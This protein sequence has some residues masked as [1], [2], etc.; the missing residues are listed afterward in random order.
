MSQNNVYSEEIRSLESAAGF[1]TD[2]FGEGYDD[3]S[4][5]LVNLA[6]QETLYGTL[7]SQ[8]YDDGTPVSLTEY[9]ID[10]IRY[11]DML[12]RSE[13]G[14]ALDRVNK[15]NEEFTNLGY[16]NFDIRNLASTE[17]MDITDPITGDVT[18]QTRY[19]DINK[20]LIEDPYVTA[21]LA[22]HII[23]SDPSKVPDTLEGQADY[24][25]ENWNTESGAGHQD[26]FIEKQQV[27][28]E[29]TD[30]EDSVMDMLR[31]QDADIFSIQ[32]PSE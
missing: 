5:Y 20:K 2:L 24:W 17:T 32:A 25:K 22:R 18:Q 1:T 3:I 31:D 29:K 26:E 9:Q 28:R 19:T 27:Y 14:A 7:P 15:I 8:V 21:T 13:I 12:E 10:P 6:G 11:N 16:E 4:E 23:A 30:V